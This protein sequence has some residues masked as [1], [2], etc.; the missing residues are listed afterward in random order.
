MVSG[1]IDIPDTQE[2]RVTYKHKIESLDENILKITMG[3]ISLDGKVE[4]VAKRIT[5]TF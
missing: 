2:E 1:L 3:Q 4:G 5:I